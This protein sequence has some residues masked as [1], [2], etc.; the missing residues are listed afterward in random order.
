VDYHVVRPTADPVA[1]HS[2]H[3]LKAHLEMTDHHLREGRLLQVKV[4][5]QAHRSI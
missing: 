2:E 1:I 3:E 5:V 4:L